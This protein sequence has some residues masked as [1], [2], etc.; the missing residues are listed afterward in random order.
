MAAAQL[1]SLQTWQ[2]GGGEDYFI[3]GFIDDCTAAPFDGCWGA[4]NHQAS[5]AQESPTV[6]GIEAFYASLDEDEDTACEEDNPPFVSAGMD[7]ECT[8]DAPCTLYGT[9]VDDSGS[10]T[11]AWT[12]DCA[13]TLTYDPNDDTAQT[14]VSND[15]AEECDFTITCNDGVNEPVTDT[16]TITFESGNAAP[17]MAALDDV[18]GFAN[19]AIAI[20]CD[21]TDDG[22]PASPGAVSYQ[23]TQT[24]GS[25][26]CTFGDDTDP[27][28]TATCDDVD[29]YTLQCECSDGALT[30]TD[31]LTASVAEE[32]Y[33]DQLSV[34]AAVC[35]S[36]SDQI[37]AT[38]TIAYRVERASDSTQQDIG[39]EADGDIDT[40]ALTT[41]C[42][43]TTCDVATCEDPSGNS[44]D[45]TQ[46]TST[47]RPT[48][49]DGGVITCGTSGKPCA[50]FDRTSSTEDYLARGDSSGITGNAAVT[51]AFNARA[52]NTAADNITVLLGTSNVGAGYGFIFFPSVARPVNSQ[53]NALRSFTTAKATTTFGY[54]I[55]SKAN[56]AQIGDSTLEHD[57]AAQTE[58][59]D[60]N[61]TNT[62]NIASSNT[63]IGASHAGTFALDGTVGTVCIFPSVLAGDD[64]T[65]TRAWFGARN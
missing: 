60:L 44:R 8:T 20:E 59:S 12:E 23:W 11:A 38:Q 64:L 6:W 14:D 51:Y 9:C 17:V 21:C 19:T 56:G 31:T 29:D 1:E 25:G 16:A 3:L 57:G 7:T 61:P 10:V 43:G 53:F 62:P 26:T 65:V 35:C 39:F 28:T 24:A 40:A 55:S 27:T 36:F 33:L 42:T 49:Y 22:L 58:F 41:F 47:R 50:D 34:S 18:N 15:T 32:R 46:A 30:D 45:L 4:Y 5:T 63:S 52:D 2:T 48:V 13:G 37:A 54:F